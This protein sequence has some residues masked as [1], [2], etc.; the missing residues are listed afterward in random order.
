MYTCAHCTVRACRDGQ[1]DQLPQNCPMRLH[2]E[3]L[4]TPLPEYALPENHE[5]YVACSEI[6]AAGYGQWPRIREIV[7][8]CHTMGYR[9]LGLAFCS[10]LQAEARIAAD[11]FRKNGL[12][13]I[14]VMCKVGH[15]AKSDVGIQKQVRGSGV[16]ETMCN[17]ILQAK[18]LNE[19]H[20]DLNV[21]F[22]LCVGHDSLFYRYSDAL[23]TT[24]V[25]KDRALAHNPIGALHCADG[26]M[27]P[28]LFPYAEE[29]T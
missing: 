16:R 9:K 12:E 3:I 10:G 22:G 4:D 1:L 20:T 6:E 14:S 15:T 8:L 29:S 5:F 21:A 13:V 23:V 25:A 26:Y 19:A 24:L 18:L 11:I 2:P 27:K 28:R 7:E 17:P